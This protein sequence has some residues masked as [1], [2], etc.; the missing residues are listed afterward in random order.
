M[1]YTDLPPACYNRRGPAEPGA[2]RGRL[3]LD[4]WFCTPWCEVSLGHA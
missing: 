4:R 1:D 2:G 3:P